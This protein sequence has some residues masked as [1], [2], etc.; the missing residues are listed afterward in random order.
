MSC[1]LLRGYIG[2]AWSGLV[3]WS[4][5]IMTIIVITTIMVDGYGIHTKGNRNRSAVRRI[6][7]HVHHLATQLV[8][9]GLFSHSS[10][11]EVGGI[12]TRHA[13]A[14]QRTWISIEL[15]KPLLTNGRQLMDGLKWKPLVKWCLCPTGN[16]QTNYFPGDALSI[17]VEQTKQNSIPFF[18]VLEKGFLHPRRT[19]G[20]D[21]IWIE[22]LILVFLVEKEKYWRNLQHTNHPEFHLISHETLF[23]ILDS[24]LVFAVA[25]ASNAFCY[26]VLHVNFN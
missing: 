13:W 15:P 9:T 19:R 22:R 2:F 6:P 12:H 10:A 17:Y 24:E 25:A 18:G 8:S 3:G 23:R 1:V 4:A 7:W 21:W 26:V 16:L 14:T 5:M 11:R 20:F